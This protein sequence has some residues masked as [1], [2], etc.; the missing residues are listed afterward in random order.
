MSDDGADECLLSFL[1]DEPEVKT[2]QANSPSKRRKLEKETEEVV[3]ED[4]RTSDGDDDGCKDSSVTWAR[5]LATAFQEARQA[6]GKQLRPL[7]V[8]SMCTGMCTHH[9]ALQ[10]RVMRRGVGGCQDCSKTHE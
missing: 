7:V 8:H 9:F 10:V 6:R 3:K 2:D 1:D 4:V 5:R